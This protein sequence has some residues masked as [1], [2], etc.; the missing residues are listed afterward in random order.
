MLFCVLCTYVVMMLMSNTSRIE[1]V[2]RGA[3][4][5][6][7]V[8]QL[9]LVPI[10]VG[11]LKVWIINTRVHVTRKSLGFEVKFPLRLNQFQKS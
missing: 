7:G 11:A 3:A 9:A 8:V 2:R 6:G 1:E 5:Y 4:V 10:Y